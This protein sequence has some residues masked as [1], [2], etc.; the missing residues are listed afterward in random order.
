MAYSSLKRKLKSDEKQSKCRKCNIKQANA[1][2]KGLWE[3]KC[4]GCNKIITFS[5][6]GAFKNNQRNKSECKS[7]SRKG[8]KN[9]NYGKTGSLNPFYGKSHSKEMK[10]RMS[11]IKRGKIM[12]EESKKKI[13]EYQKKNAPMRGRTVYSIWLQKYGKEEANRRM[14]SAKEKWRN[15]SLGSKNPMFGKPSPNGSGNGWKG[16][17]KNRFFRSLRELMFLYYADRFNLQ[18]ES[19]EKAE[20]GLKYLDFSGQERTY[21]GDYLVNNKY[22]VEIKPVKLQNSPSNI[23]KKKVALNACIEKG[24]KYKLID[25]KPNAKLIKKLFLEDRVQFTD[26]S[27]EKIKQYYNI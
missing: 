11:R 13:S 6:E 18:L 19:L 7:C 1:N 5:T 3:C 2:Q 25:P 12:S 8:E 10:E 27:K 9:P 24:W 22:F 26:K 23:A 4:P 21:F 20:Y 15:S 17:Y 16:W 14:A